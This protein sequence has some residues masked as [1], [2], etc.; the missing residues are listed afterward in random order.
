M[1]KS[2]CVGARKEEGI[3]KGNKE[4]ANIALGKSAPK[5]I[6]KKIKK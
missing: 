5:K 4:F 6:Q 2:K 3:S 1:T